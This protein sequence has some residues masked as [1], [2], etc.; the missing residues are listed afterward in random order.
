MPLQQHRRRSVTQQGGLLDWTLSRK[1]AWV[2]TRCMLKVKGL[3]L[4]FSAA[5]TP[6][7]T[8]GF[9]FS[10]LTTVFFLFLFFVLLLLLFSVQFAEGNE[11]GH[12][13]EVVELSNCL[14][15]A[16]LAV[17]YIIR[18]NRLSKA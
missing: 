13:V 15:Q 6:C 2:L 3:S 11:H 16:G 8:C 17:H 12:K 5:C 9:V 7:W 14:F 10:A 18:M 4:S 1:P